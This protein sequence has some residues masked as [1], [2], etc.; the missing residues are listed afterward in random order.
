M[1]SGGEPSPVIP[2]T[3]NGEEIAHRDAAAIPGGRG[4]VSIGQTRGSS[5]VFLHPPGGGEPV[6]LITGRLA[7]VSPSGHLVFEQD[8]TLWAVALDVDRAPVVGESVALANLA[9]AV[10]FLSP[11]FDLSVNGSLVYVTGGSGEWPNRSLYWVARDGQEE[12]LD[13]EP[14]PYW[15]PRASPDGEQI[16]FHIMDPENMDAHIHDLRSGAT[17]R[18][19]FDPA[20][21]GYPVWSPNGERIVFWSSRETGTGNLFARATD[22]TGDV[23]RLTETIRR[24][25]PYSWT[26]DGLIIFTEESSETSSDIWKLSIDG[27]RTPELVLQEP[28]AET[29]PAVSPNGRWIA[30]QSNESGQWQIWVRPFPDVEDGRW[31]VGAG[32]SP[33]WSPDSRELYFRG[34]GAMMA[35]RI[36]AADGF[37]AGPAVRLFDAPY[38][39]ATSDVAPLQAEYAVAPDGRFLMMKDVSPSE[40]AAEVIVVRNWVEELKARVPA[41]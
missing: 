9:G 5:S 39:L 40:N 27:D 13:I 19:T 26:R 32:M 23:E 35:V 1:A 31:S 7:R 20:V 24:S 25:A 3:E 21:D 28:Y 16:G 2:A 30:Y 18:L 14:R 17:S 29:R 22:G 11:M 38:V 6:L 36:D 15:F 37:S 41:P 34:D 8:G 33:Q 10:P 4:F 12:R